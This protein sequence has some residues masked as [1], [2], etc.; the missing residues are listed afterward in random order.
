M[1]L[2]ALDKPEHGEVFTRRWVVESI[3]DL[4]G[5]TPDRDLAAMRL[6]EPSTGAGAFVIPVIERLL[7]SAKM[8]NRPLADLSHAVFGF[9]LQSGHVDTC[10]RRAQLLLVAA[11]AELPDAAALARH[12][13]R[14]G[15]FLLDRVPGTANFVVGNPPYIRAEDLDD[16]VEAAYRERWSAMRGRADIYIGF[17]EHALKLL[18]D[19]GKLGFICADRWMRNAY[20]RLLRR[21]VVSDYAVETVWQ[22]HDVDA[23][24]TQVSAYPAITVIANEP[25]RG[26]TYIDTSSGF[27]ERSAKAAVAFTHSSGAESHGAGWE[28]AR[29]PNWF[30]TDDFWPAGPPKTIKLLEHLQEEF[31]TL[32]ADGRTRISIGVATGADTAYLV[33]RGASID[34]EPDRLLPIVTAADIRAGQLATP[35]KV[36]LNPWNDQGALIDLASYPK[37]AKALGS[38]RRVKERFVAKKNPAMWHRTIDKVYPGLA[39][40]PKLLLQ[41]MKARIT[42]VLEPGGLYPHHNLY[43]IVSDSWDL[44]VLGGVLL[45]RVAELFVSAYGVKM[46]GGTLRFQAQYLRKITAP[47]PESIPGDVA[48]RLRIAFRN[49]DRDAATRAAEEAYGLPP[50][51]VLEGRQ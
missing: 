38:H 6:V 18:A 7:A 8:H 4:V 29:L 50:G 31:P 32:E 23:F 37:F 5:Y 28:G 24:E 27:G 49:R 20:G 11:G 36:M 39:A 19:G 22:L 25:Q 40:T 15:D 51:T 45:S 46:R 9:D 35:S 3:L 17:Y 26:V 1:S 47:G 13:I 42:P 16:R 48:H 2:A 43:Y 34:V 14:Q 12:W 10:R 41:D 21:L 33:P 30:D 44:E